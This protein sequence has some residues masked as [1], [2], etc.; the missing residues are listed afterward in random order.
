MCPAWCQGRLRS[1]QF[2]AGGRG[3]PELC[4]RVPAP[5]A[6]RWCRCRGEGVRGQWVPLPAAPR[7]AALTQ[8]E[9]ACSGRQAGCGAWSPALSLH[10]AHVPAPS[11]HRHQAHSPA[12]SAHPGAEPCVG[13]GGGS[14]EGWLRSSSLSFAHAGEYR[15]WELNPA[16]YLTHSMFVSL[17]VNHLPKLCSAS[18]LCPLGHCLTPR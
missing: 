18:R 9:R 7:Q 4:L 5:R 14:W 15:G 6:A 1:A 16:L 8:A 11:P 3:H 10:R 17:M 13:A 2:S 12:L